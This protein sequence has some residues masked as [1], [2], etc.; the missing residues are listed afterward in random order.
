M[1]AAERGGGQPPLISLRSSREHKARGEAMRNP[2]KHG[3]TRRKAR[4]AADSSS[5]NISFVEQPAGVIGMMMR[6]HQILD[7]FTR[8]RFLDLRKR[9]DRVVVVKNLFRS[10]YSQYMI[11]E[12][13]E[14][15]VVCASCQPFQQVN[16]FGDLAHGRWWR[17][18]RR[19][20]EFCEVA[21]ALKYTVRGSRVDLHIC[22]FSFLN[23][24]AGV[25]Q[26]TSAGKLQFPDRAIA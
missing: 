6:E 25:V 3:A 16:I 22:I 20:G 17:R 18:C 4:A 21:R 11:V 2:G 14:E 15:D 13:H 24:A 8:Y 19:R 9:L 10:L 23:D 26:D 12:G 5:S 1:M 7:L